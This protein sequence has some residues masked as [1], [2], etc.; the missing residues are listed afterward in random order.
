MKI[1]CFS[2]LFGDKPLKEALKIIKNIGCEMVEIGT[3]NYPGNAHCNPESLLKNSVAMDEF[4]QIIKDSGLEISALSC[5]GNPVHPNKKIAEEHTKV[6]RQTVELA[7]KLG[8]EVVVGFSGC[9][10]ANKDATVPAWNVIAW[11]PDYLE[12]LKWQWDEVLIPFWQKEAEFAEAHNVKIAFELHPGFCVYNTA[13]MLRIRKACGKNI[14]ANFDP[15]HLFW[16]SMDPLKMIRTLKD[17]IFHVHAKDCKIDEINT[18]LNGCND[19]TPYGDEINRSW[20]FRTVGYGHDLSWWKDFV[21]QLRLVGYDYVL[22]I[23][24]EDSLMAMEEGLQKAFDCL[25]EAVISKKPGELY[26]A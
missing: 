20:I 24:H 7:A 4:K 25:K 10:G 3:G 12:S 9:P 6:H 8:V 26:W 1:G 19:P 14:G 11:P 22:S 21:S 13:T 2:V 23:E 15:S 16:Q 5:H 17:A 18:A